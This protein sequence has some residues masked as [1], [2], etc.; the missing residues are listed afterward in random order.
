MLLPARSVLGCSAWNAPRA[1]SAR[2]RLDWVGTIPDHGELRLELTWSVTAGDGAR[3]C[4]RV[5]HRVPWPVPQPAGAT[6][7]PDGLPVRCRAPPRRVA[8]RP[9]RNGRTTLRFEVFPS[10]TVV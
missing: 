6:W 4:A 9:P 2:G 8:G 7:H 1:P 10:A 5:L 3:A